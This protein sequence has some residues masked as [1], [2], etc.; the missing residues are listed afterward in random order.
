VDTHRSPFT[1]AWE[2]ADRTVTQERPSYA[3]QRKWLAFHAGAV[4]YR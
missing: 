4:Q 1:Y 3:G 2:L